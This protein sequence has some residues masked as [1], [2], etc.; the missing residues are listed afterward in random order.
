MASRNVKYLYLLK[1]QLKHV[2]TLTQSLSN[3]N[4]SKLDVKKKISLSFFTGK[5]SGTITASRLCC[6]TCAP[7]A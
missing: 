2:K 5:S 7:T 3:N 6:S 4:Y 1:N